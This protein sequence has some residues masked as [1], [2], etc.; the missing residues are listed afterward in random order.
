MDVKRHAA[1][2]QVLAQGLLDIE[3]A[4]RRFFAPDRKAVFQ[5]LRQSRHGIVHA[6]DIILSVERKALIGQGASLK[7]IPGLEAFLSLLLLDDFAQE[8]I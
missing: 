1:I 7:G 2:L 4:A 6:P 8:A 5:P 3:A